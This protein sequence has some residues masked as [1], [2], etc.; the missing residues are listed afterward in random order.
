[1][2]F[3]CEEKNVL[4]H[5]YLILFSIATK[6]GNGKLENPKGLLLMCEGVITLGNKGEKT[7]QTFDYTTCKGILVSFKLQ[8]KKEFD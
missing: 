7:G 4:R 8:N 3:K 6:K 2:I 1:M 5:H